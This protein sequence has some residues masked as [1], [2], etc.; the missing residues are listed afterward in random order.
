MNTINGIW[1]DVI[2]ELYIPQIKAYQNWISNKL[3]P[4]MDENIVE[5]E[6]ETKVE[7]YMKRMMGSLSEDS[8][9]AS[10]SENARDTGISYI[11]EMM[12]LKQGIINLFAIGL[13]HLYE[14]QM[15]RMYRKELLNYN[16]ER[17]VD[18]LIDNCDELKSEDRKVLNNFLSM[19]DLEKRLRK[20]GVD[21]TRI[22]PWRKISELKHIANT[23][24]HADGRSCKELKKLRPD[25]FSNPNPSEYRSI[26]TKQQYYIPV[27]Q[28]LAGESVYVTPELLYEYSSSIIE[29][30]K[31][32]AK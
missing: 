29:F 19:Q 8:D 6:A 4:S 22:N 2:K 11:I 21:V 9:P 32:L 26:G 14:Q 27:F 5:E 31:F 3:L 24:K 10:I 17:T 30:W 16:E 28:P 18:V 12:D 1:R 7:E 23:I 15:L 13:Y 25:L 20:K